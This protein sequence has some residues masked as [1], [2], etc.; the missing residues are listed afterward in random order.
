MNLINNR[1]QLEHVGGNVQEIQ[2]R[3]FPSV[4]SL[5]NPTY[6]A[7]RSPVMS[8]IVNN[9]IHVMTVPTLPEHIAILYVMSTVIRWQISPTKAN[10]DSMPH[11]LRPTPSQLI[12]PHSIWL[13][14]FT[15]PKA[16]ERMCREAKYQ[17][18]HHVLSRI[19][20]ES[21]SINWPH[22]PSDMIMKIN[23]SDTILN[24]IFEGHIRNLKNW[25]V[26]KRILDV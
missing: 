2:R 22:Q 5:L 7:V 13:D 14:I 18:Q 24:S 25:T 17:N 10:Y 6:E 4:Q 3:A 8:T 19:C 21:I 1:R 20:N 26:G 12:H 16:R 11:W 15:W 9:I 23:V